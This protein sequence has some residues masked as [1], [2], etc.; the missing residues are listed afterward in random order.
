MD[1]NN[2]DYENWC[3]EHGTFYYWTNADKRLAESFRELLIQFNVLFCYQELRNG[4]SITITGRYIDAS[5]AMEL[6]K[7]QFP[8]MYSLSCNR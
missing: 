3:N 5:A 8:E 4:V 6:H 2:R 7:E 1:L